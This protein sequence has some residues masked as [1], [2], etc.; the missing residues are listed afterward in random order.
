MMKRSP[1]HYYEVTI[2][3][4]S[5]NFEARERQQLRGRARRDA[6]NRRQCVLLSSGRRVWIQRI[7]V[8]V[9]KVEDVQVN[10]GRQLKTNL[11]LSASV[12]AKHD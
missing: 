11:Q 1:G 5:L 4:H 2:R 6:D 9:W 3:V 7:V 12:Q 10:H 8:V